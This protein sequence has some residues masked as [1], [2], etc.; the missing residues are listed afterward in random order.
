[1]KDLIDSIRLQVHERMSSPLFGS[2]VIAWLGWNYR[3]LVVVFSTLPVKERFEVIDHQ[4]YATPWAAWSKGLFFPLASALLFILIYP[5][6]SKWIWPRKFF[7]VNS[8]SI[9]LRA[10]FGIPC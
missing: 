7:S 5:Y 10:G 4:L 6:P 2:F 8:L 9:R 3:M 1:M